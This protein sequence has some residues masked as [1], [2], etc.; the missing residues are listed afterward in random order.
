MWMAVSRYVGNDKFFDRM[1]ILILF[2]NLCWD[3]AMKNV[4]RFANYPYFCFF[5]HIN[6]KALNACVHAVVVTIIPCASTT[7]ALRPTK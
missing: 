6:D 5:K 2:E 3:K 7:V 4:L 1:L